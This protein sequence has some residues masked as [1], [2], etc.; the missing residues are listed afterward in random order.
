MSKRAVEMSH[1][2]WDIGR[3]GFG[4][5]RGLGYPESWNENKCTAECR[6]IRGRLFVPSRWTTRARLTFTIPS[7]NG[8]FILTWGEK[9]LVRE[10]SIYMKR[11]NL[12]CTVTR[13]YI[14]EAAFTVRSLTWGFDI[15][16]SGCI[17]ANMYN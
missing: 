6:I 11:A 12:K 5:R 15:I 10:S 2:A 8:T 1:W 13:A 9:E 17:I 7:R 16:N 3:V 4:P 14:G